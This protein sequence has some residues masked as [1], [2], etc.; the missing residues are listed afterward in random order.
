MAGSFQG[1]DELITQINVT[2]L[3]DIVL[4]LL[5]IFMVTSEIVHEAQ[6]PDVVQIQLPIAASADKLIAEGLLKI[7]IDANGQ[8]YLYGAKA[9][10][11]ALRQALAKIDATKK[12]PQAIISADERVAHGKVVEVGDQL[13]LL[14]VERVVWDTLKQ[15]IE[16]E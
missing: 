2:P 12:E 5:I 4:V 7:E 3:V 8:V 1:D 16:P 14:G 10:Q 6:R 15:R 13:R 11:S 9:D